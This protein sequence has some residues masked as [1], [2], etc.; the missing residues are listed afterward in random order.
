LESVRKDVEYAYWKGR[1][2]ILKLPQYR[3]V[4][5]ID[6][7]FFTCCILHN[8]LHAF[9]GLDVRERG[10][11][12]QWDGDDGMHDE[13][14]AAPTALADFGGVGLRDGD[15]AEDVEVEND[16]CTLR[17]KLITH[18]SVKHAQGGYSGCRVSMAVVSFLIR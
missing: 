6:N 17:A 11:H 10:V 3:T 18:F 7:I 9:D 4:A 2:R 14:F 12:W 1:F 5:K 16:F 8:M 15:D 13:L